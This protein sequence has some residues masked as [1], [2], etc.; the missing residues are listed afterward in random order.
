MSTISTTEK[1]KKQIHTEQLT[2][3][4][5]EL[6]GAGFTVLVSA[7]HPFEWLHFEKDGKFGTVGPDGFYNYNFGTVHKPCR[8]CGTGYGMARET[9]LTIEHATGCLIYAPGWAT[10]SDVKAIRKYKDVQEFINSTH[11]KWA[12]YYIY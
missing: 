12:E 4:A 5:D 7:L 3:F 9:N 11:N 1:T 8:E 2:A 10:S 6:R